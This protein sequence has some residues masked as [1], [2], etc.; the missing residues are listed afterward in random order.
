M[1][2]ELTLPF[3]TSFLQFTNPSTHLHVSLYD[4]LDS[5]FRL[6]KYS[7]LLQEMQAMKNT[8]STFLKPRDGE[9][10]VCTWAFNASGEIGTFFNE[11]WGGAIRFSII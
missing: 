7:I 10:R 1:L 8:N 5:G 4:L 3:R 6:L 11:E 9:E 2:L